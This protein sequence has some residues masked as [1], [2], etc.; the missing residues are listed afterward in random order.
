MFDDESIL[1]SFLQFAIIYYESAKVKYILD[2]IKK[3]DV[4]D[5]KSL[6]KLYITFKK[7]KITSKK[8]LRSWIRDDKQLYNIYNI[9]YCISKDMKSTPIIESLF[10]KLFTEI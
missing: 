3:E 2:L 7:R 10:N 4:I 1:Q 8:H 9:V 5:M 6:E